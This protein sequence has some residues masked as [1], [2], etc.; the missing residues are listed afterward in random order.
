MI[1]MY[2]SLYKFVYLSTFISYK[3]HIKAKEEKL[4]KKKICIFFIVELPLVNQIQ[5]KFKV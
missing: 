1:F 4:D 3:G 5:Q 2:I